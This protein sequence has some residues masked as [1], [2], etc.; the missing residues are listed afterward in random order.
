M[1]KS[2]V[3]RVVLVAAV[4]LTGCG[5]AEKVAS[6]TSTSPTVGTDSGS[7]VSDSSVSG[8]SNS[9]SVS[10]NATYPHCADVWIIGKRLPTGY[11]GTCSTP[12]TTDSDGG[13]DC[14][15]GSHISLD[16][17]GSRHLYALPGE[18]IKSMSDQAWIEYLVGTCKPM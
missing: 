11:A 15:D 14:A 9:G 10:T 13:Y 3:G 6:R 18:A 2:L 5:T 7:S 4:A 17:A 16:D 12:T 8:S 1:R